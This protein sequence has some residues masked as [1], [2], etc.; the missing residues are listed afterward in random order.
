L[1]E[2]GVQLLT[3]IGFDGPPY[4]AKRKFAR[5]KTILHYW[6]LLKALGFALVILMLSSTMKKRKVEGKAIALSR[7]T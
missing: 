6:N 2:G 5:E 1:S 7:A 4:R 3:L